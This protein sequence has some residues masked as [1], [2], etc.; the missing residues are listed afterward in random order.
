MSDL[1]RHT[2]FLVK[3]LAEM[4]LDVNYFQDD[5]SAQ[6]QLSL[7]PTPFQTLAQPFVVSAVRF[8]TLG[9]SK[10]KFYAPRIFF[11]LPPIDVGR[12]TDAHDVE[13]ALRRAWSKRLKDLRAAQIWLEELGCEPRLSTRGARLVLP[14]AD[15]RNTPACVVSPSEMIVPSGG[16]LSD[17]SLRD[18]AERRFRPLRNLDHSSE[19]EIGLAQHMTKLATQYRDV[20]VV[21]RVATADP[22]LV[23]VARVLALEEEP[24]AAQAMQAALSGQGFDVFAYHDPTRA[25]EAFHEKSFDLVLADARMRRADGMEFTARIQELAGIEKLPVVLVDERA[26]SAAQRAAHAAGAS[27]YWAKPI[28]WTE[29]SSTLADL[30]EATNWRRFVRYRLRMPVEVSLGTRATSELTHTIARAGVSIAT[31]R[32]VEPGTIERY[33]IKLPKPLPPILVDGMVMT[34][35]ARPGS[36]TLLA[37]I[38]FLRFLDDGELHWIR[39]IEELAR[40]GLGT[41]TVR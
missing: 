2:Q 24:L 5:L 36:V 21:A 39:L 31:R 32:E 4:G 38:Q 7:A 35:Q 23:R 25:L 13:S 28:S 30:I 15:E 37:G 16:P 40:R 27:A 17:V 14:L 8:Y 20:S 11:E 9:H 26:N 29:I 33:R 10:L 12:C 6:G 41:Q 22:N 18:P 34:R 19:L 1:S 3:R